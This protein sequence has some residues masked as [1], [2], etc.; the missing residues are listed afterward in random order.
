MTDRYADDARAAV[1]E[2]EARGAPVSPEFTEA[3]TDEIR[4]GLRSWA[5]GR[6]GV[7]DETVSK[8]VLQYALHYVGQAKMAD[9]NQS[10][11]DEIHNRQRADIEKRQELVAELRAIR[12][13]T[14]LTANAMSV[15]INES[16]NNVRNAEAGH[17]YGIRKFQELVEK[18]SAAEEIC[19]RM[20]DQTSPVPSTP[21]AAKATS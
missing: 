2:W 13:R 21:P 18:Y 19:A 16:F 6:R 15:L 7:G 11:L 20:P 10:R 12:A 17:A 3:Q 4:E 8:V 5:E 1:E 9:A 14:G